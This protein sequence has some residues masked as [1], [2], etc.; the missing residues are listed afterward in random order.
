MFVILVLVLLFIPNSAQGALQKERKE[1]F[2]A[3]TANQKAQ[4]Q[5]DVFRENKRIDGTVKNY[6]VDFQYPSTKEGQILAVDQYILKTKG[7]NKGTWVYA[8]TNS[9]STLTGGDIL[10]VYGLTAYED[11]LLK[12]Y[13]EEYPEGGGGPEIVPLFEMFFYPYP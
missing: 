11:V 10:T 7:R 6:D 3:I 1:V 13:W 12:F 5:I 4:L 9:S 2:P 8:T